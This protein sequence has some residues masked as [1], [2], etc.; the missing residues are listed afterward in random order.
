MN[1]E[2]RIKALGIILKRVEKEFDF[3]A[4]FLMSG[5]SAGR[6]KKDYGTARRVLAYLAHHLVFGDFSKTAK[7]LGYSTGQSCRCAIWRLRENEKELA[8]AERLAK[9]LRDKYNQ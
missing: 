3:P 5:Q 7:F 6:K 8:I 1:K 9:Q 2:Q 4:R